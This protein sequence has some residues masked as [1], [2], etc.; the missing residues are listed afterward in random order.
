MA[1]VATVTAEPTTITDKLPIFP[2]MAGQASVRQ[3]DV[4]GRRPLSSLDRSQELGDR[5]VDIQ[6]DAA[7]DISTKK[8][9]AMATHCE[10]F[11]PSE[12]AILPNRSPDR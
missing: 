12:S 8:R 10:G 11:R 2:L 7:G 1:P 9:M 6:A 4:A 5:D 3:C